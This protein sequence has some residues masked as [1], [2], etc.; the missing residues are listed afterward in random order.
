MR[1]STALLIV[2]I[3]AV[4]ALAGVSLR[5]T[6]ASADAPDRADQARLAQSAALANAP[7][8]DQSASEP[9][10]LASDARG[11]AASVAKNVPLPSGGTLDGI[12]WGAVDG[13]VGAAEVQRVVQYNA[14]CQWLRALRDGRDPDS[15]RS[16]ASELSRW[17]ALRAADSA[18]MLARAAAAAG[19]SADAVGERVIV[20][21]DASHLREI[22][23]ASDQGLTPST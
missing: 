8:V 6:S 19:G 20:D 13:T 2:A 7:A 17:S 12:Q 23:Y 14:A 16:I 15:A 4:I 3:V 1:G 5:S 11:F 21:C 22:R 18:P 10:F 9:Q